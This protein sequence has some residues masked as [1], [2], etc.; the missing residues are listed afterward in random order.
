ML[1]GMEMLACPNLAVSPEIMRHVVHVESSANPYAIGVVGGQLEH[2]PGSLPEAL[3]TVRMLD[4]KGYNFSVGLAQ[5]NR[6][7]LDRY[8]LDSYPKSFNACANLSAG[9]QILAGC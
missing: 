1:P 4:A 6:A 3:A 8:G 7:N 2:Q 9:A 5:V